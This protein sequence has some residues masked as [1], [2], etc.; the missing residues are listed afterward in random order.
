LARYLCVTGHPRGPRKRAAHHVIASCIV[1]MTSLTSSADRL[2]TSLE[3]AEADLEFVAHRLQQ[4]LG[5]TYSSKANPMVLLRRIKKLQELLPDVRMAAE[6]VLVAKQEMVDTLKN[7]L[8]A[9][10][11]ALDR[12]QH[13]SGAP[14]SEHHIAVTAGVHAALKEWDLQIGLQQGVIGI[15][16]LLSR[17]DLNT[18][19]F[20]SA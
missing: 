18:N 3:T 16:D 10:A 17:T 12:L 1:F 14:V 15:N 4:E 2:S 6:E 13:T 7:T 9:N 11:T 5:S 19:L 20:S 8:M